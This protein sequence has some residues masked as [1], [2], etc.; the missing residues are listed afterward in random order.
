MKE[1]S[2]IKPDPTFKSNLMAF[3][4]ECGDGWLPLIEELFDKIQNLLDTKY[5]E[6]KENF[7]VLQVKEKYATLRVYTTGVPN[8]IYNLIDEYELKSMHICEHCGK[9]GE[10]KLSHGWWKTLC[11]RCFKRYD[12]RFERIAGYI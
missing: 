1:Y 4:Y 12:S 10:I 6:E 3:G 7:Q 8:E 2:F 9:K 11:K 5:P